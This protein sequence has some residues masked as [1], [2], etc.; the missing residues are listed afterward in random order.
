MGKNE[1]KNLVIHKASTPP[2]APVEGQIY[3]N[4]SD[5]KLYVYSS[6]SWSSS[7]IEG[8]SYTKAEIDNMFAQSGNLPSQTGN[9]GKVL[10]TNGSVASWNHIINIHKSDQ[11]TQ[12]ISNLTINK[13]SKAEYDS[14]VN[15]GQI[16][17]SELY[18]I[19]DI[20]T[21]ID[22]KAD[23]GISYTKDEVDQLLNEKEI[24]EVLIG[25]ESPNLNLVGKLGQLYINTD[26]D[27]VYVCSKIVTIEDVSGISYQ[28][29]WKDI[30]TIGSQ[31]STLTITL[32][33]DNWSQ[34]NEQE[35]Q[36]SGINNNQTILV[37]PKTSN[38]Y[39]NEDLYLKHRIW[40]KSQDIN[41]LVFGCKSIPQENISVSISITE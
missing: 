36:I 5:G 9:S 13:L 28:Y 26:T 34:D 32:S 29:N 17:E 10:T 30:T 1:L 31:T 16:K 14:L 24:L 27:I 18:Q 35:I 11:T 33:A 37:S 19:T 41:K 38:D 7:G 2:T 4:T 21:I 6:N 22:N 8:D 23:I 15:A 3:Y 20:S 39:S 12:N 40:C 25:S